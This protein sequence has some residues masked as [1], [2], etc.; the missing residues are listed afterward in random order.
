[1]DDL[2]ETSELLAFAKTIETNS[3]SRAAIE[4][5]VPRATVGRRL[6]RLEERL[7]ARLLRRTTRS[8]TLTDAGEALYRH[9]RIV[10][11]AVAHAEASVRRTDAVI[12]GDLRVSVPPL[13]SLSFY[14]M[15]CEFAQ[16]YPEV[17]MHIHFS[18]QHVDLRRGAYDVAIRASTDLEPGLIARTLSHAQVVA[19]ASPAYLA[20]H[21]TPRSPRDLRDHRCLMSFTRGEFPQ[22]H[23]PL[24]GGSKL[25]VEGAFFSNE[26]TLL[27]DAAVRGLG[28]AFL[29]WLVVG[30]AIESGA[31][32]QVL[33]GIVEADSR[34][35]AV[36]LERE[37]VPPQVRA[38]VD[39]VAA[40]APTELEKGA[41]QCAETLV[42]APR[43][44]PKLEIATK[45]KQ[46]AAKPST[47]RQTGKAPTSGA[48]GKSSRRVQ[49]AARSVN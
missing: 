34:V 26:I 38:F 19:V 13:M 48:R 37:F 41:K 46:R 23:W 44:S 32:V 12:R 43:V 7:G 25:Q 40:W 28:I 20:Q 36:Y 42:Q 16:R 22:T 2:V 3:L 30:D 11:D 27:C 6:A 15:V 45:A 33:P 5:G 31:L 21:G 4:L 29:P 49:T 47:K 1:M 14:A 10:L 17:R 35:A 9:A 24:V 18:T 8:L 39:A